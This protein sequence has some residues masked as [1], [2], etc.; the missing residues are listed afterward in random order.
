[1]AANVTTTLEDTEVEP[2]M[3]DGGRVTSGGRVRVGGKRVGPPV[4]ANDADDGAAEP[5]SRSRLPAVGMAVGTMVGATLG[6]PVDAVGAM[7]GAPVFSFGGRR[8]I[9]GG[10]SYDKTQEKHM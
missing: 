4:G 8:G 9:R 3:S 1:M 2:E 6:A 7:L 10:G 5:N